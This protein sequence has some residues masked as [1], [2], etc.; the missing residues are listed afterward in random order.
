[1]YMYVPFMYDFQGA[2]LKIFQSVKM[3]LWYWININQSLVL[4]LKEIL[5]MPGVIFLVNSK[6]VRQRLVAGIFRYNVRRIKQ[7]Q[8][9][10]KIS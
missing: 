3:N 4:Y 9:I 10:W 1:M 6:T 2:T 8:N 5:I 7:L